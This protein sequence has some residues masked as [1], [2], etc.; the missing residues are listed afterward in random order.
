VGAEA[1]TASSS[2]NE[3]EC[4]KERNRRANHERAGTIGKLNRVATGREPY[5]AKDA[6]GAK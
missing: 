2:K 6:I 5:G 3:N 1:R 4:G